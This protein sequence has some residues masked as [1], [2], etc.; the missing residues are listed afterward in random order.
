MTTNLVC[1]ET[2]KQKMIYD[3]F[4]RYPL[5]YFKG[6]NLKSEVNLPEGFKRDQLDL[7]VSTC[8]KLAHASEDF[9]EFHHALI[10]GDYSFFKSNKAE[11]EVL[12]NLFSI[13]NKVGV[14]NLIHGFLP[15]AVGISINTYVKP[16][17]V[18]PKLKIA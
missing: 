8:G 11:K 18:T 4:I 17:K 9:E 10:S 12:G 7:I 1:L 6:F 3:Q 13:V 5:E 14:N 16:N 2:Q 15:E